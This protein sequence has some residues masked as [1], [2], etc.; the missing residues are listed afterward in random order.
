MLLSKRL[1]VHILSLLQTKSIK[2]EFEGGYAKFTQANAKKFEHD[3][4]GELFS[5]Y[6]RATVIEYIIEVEAGI[7]ILLN[8]ERGLFLKWYFNFPQLL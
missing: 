5:S 1:K 6:E 7:D 8:R 2:A 3:P 4:N